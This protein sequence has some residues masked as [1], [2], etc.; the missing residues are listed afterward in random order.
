MVA[1]GKPTPRRAAT[2]TRAARSAAP[3][4]A[5]LAIGFAAIVALLS[6]ALTTCIAKTQEV[7]AVAGSA[8]S[9]E[10]RVSFVA[11]GD[12]LPEIGI[13]EYADSLAGET[14]DGVY[15]YAPIYEPIKPYVESAD[16]AYM[17]QETHLGGGD[18][19]PRGYPSFNTTDEMADAVVATGFDLVA[20]AT[21]HSY[22]WGCYGA[23]DHSLAVWSSKPV[24][25]TGTAASQEQADRLAIVERNGI[26][27]ALLD[28]TYGVNGYTQTDLEPYSVNFIDE[29]RI[30]ADVARAKEAADV[31]LV[32]MHW[33]TENLLEA[34][35]EQTRWAQ[36]LADLGVD[37]VL[38]SHP[39]VIG[40]L[41]WVEGEGGGKTL[42]A[43]SLG[44][45]LSHH[46][47]PDLENELEGM[48]SCDFVRREDGA[49]SVENVTWIPL[50]N[51]S[52]DGYHR[53]Y[54][55][56]DYTP[57][58]ASRHRIFGDGAA[59]IDQ[60]RATTRQVIGEEFA[61]DDGA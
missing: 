24:A 13:A 34:D 54:A 40:P 39:H 60:M 51:H 23:V 19:G 11:V 12:N 27:F 33:G 56:K 31:V 3:R 2:S 20:S 30:R 32:A 49:V 61:I 41:Q 42:V 15:D 5:L 6:F 36:L 55:L 47:T 22:D 9:Q 45:F 44:N 43:Y 16:L 26:S 57:E 46:E 8:E 25:F 38:G 1:R 29:D 21:N 4:I 7:G 37:V 58:I 50:V 18:I 53:V 48:L 59:A 35:E 14:G 10:R 52:E 28:Y 17:K